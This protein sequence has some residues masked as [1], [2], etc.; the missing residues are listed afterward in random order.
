MDPNKFIFEKPALTG[1]VARWQIILTEYDIQYTTQKA[2][3]G[4]VLANYLAHQ[5]GQDGYQPMKFEFLDEDIMFI[6]DCNI[7]GPDEGLEPESRWAMVFDGASNALRNGV[8]SVI[9]SQKGFH[10]PF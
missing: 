7:P 6:W 3:K 2:I 1:R 8:G 5:P 10:I 9:T 4:S